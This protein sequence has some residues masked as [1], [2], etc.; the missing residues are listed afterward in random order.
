L[1]D[2]EVAVF[3]LDRAKQLE[4]EETGLVVDGMG[5]VRERLLQF[6]TGVGRDLDWC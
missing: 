6:R 2:H 5:T 4:A 3:A 1:R